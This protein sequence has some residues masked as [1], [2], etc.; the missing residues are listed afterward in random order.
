MNGNRHR[1]ARNRVQVGMRFAFVAL[2]LFAVCYGCREK[3]S[4]TEPIPPVPPGSWTMYLMAPPSMFRNAP[5]GHV[6]N[7]TIPLRL[8]DPN[9]IV[10]SNVMV[11]SQCDVSRDSV[12]PNAWTRT[13]TLNRPWGCEP[14]I[15][16]WGTGGPDGREVVRSWAFSITESDTDTLAEAFASFKVFDPFD[17]LR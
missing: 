11:I 15:I 8:F 1:V 16:Y 3:A 7:D 10:R 2:I 9:G 6:E 5:G 17:T 4:P 12:T 13:D 14:A